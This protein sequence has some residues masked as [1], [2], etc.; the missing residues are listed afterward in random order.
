M[1]ENLLD[2]CDRSR[3]QDYLSGFV[4]AL[5]LERRAG[6]LVTREEERIIAFY[7]A[8]CANPTAPIY[9]LVQMADRLAG[10]Y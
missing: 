2:K 1:L 3:L 7:M 6:R 9:K 5:N 10:I 4:H 8:M